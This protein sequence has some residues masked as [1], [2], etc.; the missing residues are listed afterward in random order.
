MAKKSIYKVDFSI[1]NLSLAE[2]Q[3]VFEAV[4]KKLDF[5]QRLDLH[6]TVT[7]SVG[8][9]HF[10]WDGYGIDPNGVKCPKCS[11]IDCHDCPIY[12]GRKK[13]NE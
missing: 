2:Q 13:L 10:I 6:I 5:N 11:G 3:E 8:G 7:D 1:D 9:R 4:I 12:N